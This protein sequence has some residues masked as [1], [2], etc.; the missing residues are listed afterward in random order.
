MNSKICL[1]YSISLESC[2]LDNITALIKELLPLIL[3]D[4]FELILLEFAEKYKES[5]LSDKCNCSNNAKLKWAHKVGRKSTVKTQWGDAKI[6]QLQMQCTS[7]G[8]KKSMARPL[9]NMKPRTQVGQNLKENVALFTSLMPFRVCAKMLKFIGVNMSRTQAWRCTQEIGEKLEFGLDED[10]CK[11]GMADGTGIGIQGIKKRGRELKIFAQNK[12]NG[13]LHIAGVNIGKYESADNWREIFEPLKESFEEMGEFRLSIDGDCAILKG[14]NADI[15]LHIQRCLWHIPHQFKHYLW[16]DNVKR[17]SPLWLK[18]MAQCLAFVSLP[19]TVIDDTQIIESML[20]QKEEAYEEL[21]ALLEENDCS[22]CLAHIKNAYPNMFTNFSNQWQGKTPSLIERI[23][24][25]VNL[26]VNVG[27]WSTTGVLNAI[28][29]RLS[30][31]Y[32]GFNPQLKHGAISATR[33]T[34]TDC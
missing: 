18:V 5:E 26:R 20:K 30:Y 14:F 15:D 2:T 23:M 1:N 19:K 22:S 32:N 33:L 8:Q 13:K 28:K 25:T 17:K 6:P 29:I 11:S 31:Y 24:R 10:G 9:L 4:I 34:L 27:K 21:V 3:E 7:C 16:M 12:P